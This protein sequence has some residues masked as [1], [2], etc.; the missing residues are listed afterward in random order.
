MPLVKEPLA[1]DNHLVLSIVIA[2]NYEKY[3][4]SHYAIAERDIF[5][6]LCVCV[7]VCVCVGGGG[8][9]GGGGSYIKSLDYVY[10]KIEYRG[11][12]QK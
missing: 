10:G 11:T 12:L 2:N 7:C 8:G 9:G 3:S 4:A 1:I 6:C 5:R